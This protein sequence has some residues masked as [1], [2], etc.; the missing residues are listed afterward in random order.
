MNANYSIVH[1]NFNMYLCVCL[2]GTYYVK[3]EYIG[4]GFNIL[5]SF[6]VHKNF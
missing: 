3:Q 6:K 4:L 1:R 2:Y 5:Y